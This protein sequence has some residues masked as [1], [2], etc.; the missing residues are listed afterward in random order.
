MD[1]NTVLGRNEI[2]SAMHSGKP[3]KS[4]IKTVLG[5][6]IVQIWDNFTEKPGEIILKGDP[7]KREQTCIV[8]VWSE[9]EDIF[10]TRLNRK[11]F[12]TGMIIPFKRAEEPVQQEKPIEQSTDE[13]LKAII[14]KK[15]LGLSSQL[16]KINS[17]AVLFRMRSLAE[18]M[19]KSEKITRAIESRISELQADETA[20]K[21]ENKIEE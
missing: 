20:P 4:Y 9:K 21:T 6:V 12:A 17:V 7:K 8:D 3:F 18:E 2:F 16:N 1:T 13:E 10:F 11:H 14:N 15:F 5:K 19:E